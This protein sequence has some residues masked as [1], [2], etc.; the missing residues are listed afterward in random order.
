VRHHCAP[1]GWRGRFDGNESGAD[2]DL[3]F[4]IDADGFAKPVDWTRD[5]L[6]AFYANGN[7]RID[8]ITKRFGDDRMPAS[9]KL[10][11]WDG[12]HG[13]VLDARDTG[14]G[15]LQVWRDANQD[16]V[17]HASELALLQDKPVARMQRSGIRKPGA[18]FP[19]IPLRCI[20]ATCFS[21]P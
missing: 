4:D 13:G 7:G 20:R 6:L 1:H 10:R 11:A 2:G 17:S 5:G 12:N 16:G 14:F 3:Y 19:R 21:H 15:Q 8:D 9:S 18:P